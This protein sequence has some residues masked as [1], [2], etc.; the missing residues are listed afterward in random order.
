ANEMP[1]IL[2]MMEISPER[3]SEPIPSGKKV[4]NQLCAGCHGAD[5]KG[6]PAHVYPSLVGIDNRMSLEEASRLVEGGKGFMPSFGFLANVERTALV[7][8]LFGVVVPEDQAPDLKPYGGQPEADIPYT[9]TGYN[10]FF[11]PEGY[12]A[13]KP[14]WGTLN[15]ISLNKGTIEWSVPLGEFPE[16]IRRG[17]PP[18]GTENYGRP[19][20]T[21]GGLLFIGATR[22]EKFRA[23]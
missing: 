10:R 15:A 3:G 21:A 22:D 7:K 4:Y 17:I 11:D 1:W 16:L 13:V 8:F 14:P 20:V 23:F 9:H 6:D 19:V 2:T 12:P 18:T 5:R